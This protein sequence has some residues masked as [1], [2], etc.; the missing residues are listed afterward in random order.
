[1]SRLSWVKEC[2]NAK[3]PRPQY[4]AGQGLDEICVISQDIYSMTNYVESQVDVSGS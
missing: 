2:W 4:V 3:G 1:M